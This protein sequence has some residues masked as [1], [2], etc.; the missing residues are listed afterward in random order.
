MYQVLARRW[1]PQT[2]A[3]L[4]GQEAVARTLRN[5]VAA[6]RIAHAYLFAGV[7]GTGKTTVARVLAKCVNCERG[8]T[9]EPCLQ[10]V[11]CREIA[12]GRA[13]DVLELDAASRTGVDD[14]REL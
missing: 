1:R 5:A 7:R 12:D 4:I 2:L 14:I 3:D 11:P 10:C 13:L 9:A 6:G 8:P